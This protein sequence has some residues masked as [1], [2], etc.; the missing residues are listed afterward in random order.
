MSVSKVSMKIGV[1]GA[2]KMAGALVRGWVNSG[3][4]EAS[5]VWVD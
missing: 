5:K 2:G 4:V 1:V 3:T